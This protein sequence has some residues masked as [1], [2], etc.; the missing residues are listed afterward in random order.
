M[1]M[2]QAPICWVKMSS[3]AAR[4]RLIGVDAAHQLEIEL[5]DVRGAG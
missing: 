5:H 4:A 1:A 3:P 2:R